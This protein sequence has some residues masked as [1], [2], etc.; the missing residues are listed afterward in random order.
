M[1]TQNVTTYVSTFIISETRY[2]DGLDR[3][4]IRIFQVDSRDGHGN[5]VVGARKPFGFMAW[6]ALSV[7]KKASPYP[8]QH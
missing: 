2:L 4:N 3:G 1:K 8:C 6:T 5:H 7:I